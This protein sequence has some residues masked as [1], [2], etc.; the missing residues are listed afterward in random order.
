MTTTEMSKAAVP[1]ESVGKSATEGETRARTFKRLWGPGI[2][3]K[4]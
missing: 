3:A 4:E 2:D 1:P